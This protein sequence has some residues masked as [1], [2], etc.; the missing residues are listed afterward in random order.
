MVTVNRYSKNPILSPN[1]KNSWEEEATFNGCVIKEKD[2][3]FMVYRAMSASQFYY[4]KDIEL[5][6]IGFAESKDGI[7]FN[8]RRLFITPEYKWEQ[9]GCEDPRVTK[10]ENKFYIF[11]T[12]LADF[13]HTPEGI[14]IGVVVT[15]DFKKVEAVHQVTNFNSKA[16]TLFPSPVFNKMAAILTVN[17]DYPPAKIAVAYFDKEEQLWSQEYWKQWQ[18]SMER[19]VIPLQ[20]RIEDHI[21][22]GAPPIKTDKGWLLIYSYMRNYLKPPR[23][24]GIEAVLLDIDNP[25]RIIGRTTEPLLVPETKYE[26]YGKVPDVIFPSGALL[27]KDTLNIYYGAADTTCCLAQVNINDLLDDLIVE[28]K[29]NFFIKQE[30]QLKLKRYDKNPIIKPKPENSWES[31]YTLNPGAIYLN[32]KVHILYRAMGEDS[33]SVL[34]YASSKDGFRIDTRLTEPV[35]VPREDFEK[36]LKP[37]NSGCEDPR[38][39][40]L[41]SK[42]YMCYT[43]FDARNPTHIALT[44]ISVKDFT[45]KKWNWSKAKIISVPDRSDKNACL[46][47]E[48]IKKHFV[49]FHRIGGCI[50]IDY[51]D[52]LNFGQDRWVGGKIILSPRTDKWDSK[53][54]GIAGPPVKTKDGWLLIYHGLSIYD[55]KYRLGAVLLEL[56]NPDNVLCRLDYPILEPDVD[57]EN[58]GVRPGTVFSCGTVVINDKLFVYYGGADEVTCVATIEVQKL[59]KEIKKYS[60]V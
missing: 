38:I 47:S 60:L 49:F 42:L 41:G 27:E 39:T 28:N 21:E 37:G 23:I 4:G 12:A 11:Y 1:I 52:D 16:M 58:K 5:S 43:A 54:I 6:S 29:N 17:S 9:F 18:N 30:D 35:Y 56:E 15:K 44:S 22:I 19:Y 3:Y 10:Y 36:K 59:L 31:K 34:G 26:L 32:N 57:C 46:L 55:N 53:K 24:C 13:P 25:V 14:K 50:W 40:K 7:N 33:T 8:A 2:K 20:R 51:V 48:K 45:E